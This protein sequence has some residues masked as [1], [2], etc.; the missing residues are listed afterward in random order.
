M[1]TIV[2]TDTHSLSRWIG[3]LLSSVEE[4]QCVYVCKARHSDGVV[5]LRVWTVL[6]PVTP[7]ARNKV[8]ALEAE[9][10][11]RFPE[12]LFDFRTTDWCDPG[13]TYR[14]VD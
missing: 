5:L 14:R 4:A 7:E 8:Y 12:L 6:D 11:K 2:N 13:G 10:M 9:L 3:K 1:N